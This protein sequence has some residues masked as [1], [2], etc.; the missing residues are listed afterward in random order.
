MRAK[1]RELLIFAKIM[2]FCADIFAVF[3]IFLFA[4]IYFVHWQQNPIAALKDPFFIA[5]IL[6]PFMPAAVMAYLAAKKRKEIRSLLEEMEKN[7]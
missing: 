4:Y 2:Q 1:L 5:T 3:G 7:A 6:I